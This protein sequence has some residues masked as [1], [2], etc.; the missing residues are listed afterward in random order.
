[1]M[2][3]RLHCKL[4]ISLPHALS[5]IPYASQMLVIDMILS[6][7]FQP[8]L[9]CCEIRNGHHNHTVLQRVITLLF[10]CVSCGK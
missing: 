10:G 1:M 6:G 3:V 4:S 7:S 2:F 5:V 9:N 8:A